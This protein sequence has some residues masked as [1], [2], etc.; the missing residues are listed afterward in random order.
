MAAAEG[1]VGHTEES[2]ESWVWYQLCWRESTPTCKGR[3]CLC[4]RL[5]QRRF[6][7]PRR[8]YEYCRGISKKKNRSMGKHVPRVSILPNILGVARRVF[9]LNNGVCGKEK[10]L[11]MERELREC[12]RAEQSVCS[13]QTWVPEARES[14]GAVTVTAS[15][16][17]T[18]CRGQGIKSGGYWET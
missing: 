4:G 15:P 13:C 2:R 8:Q 6:E 18:E 1:V 3:I 12:Q 14:S 11:Q 16:S 17:G 10:A 5:G 9:L 7:C